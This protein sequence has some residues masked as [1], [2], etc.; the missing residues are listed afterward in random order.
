[1]YLNNTNRT[2]DSEH[3]KLLTKYETEHNNSDSVLTTDKVVAKNQPVFY[4]GINKYLPDSEMD[5]YI[6]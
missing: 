6:D 2:S 1:M 4:G 3:P 5:S